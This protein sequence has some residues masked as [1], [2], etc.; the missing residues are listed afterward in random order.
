MYIMLNK[1]RF[2]GVAFWA[3][4]RLAEFETEITR[5]LPHFYG[6]FLETTLGLVR[7]QDYRTMK[8]A[9]D[10]RQRW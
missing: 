8:L 7:V 1:G 4:L 6:R 10:I 5:V 9:G 3:L 2:I